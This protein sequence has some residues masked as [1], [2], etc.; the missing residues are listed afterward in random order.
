M[1]LKVDT[2]SASGQ[3]E[4]LLPKR[5]HVKMGLQHPRRVIP[6]PKKPTG[7]FSIRTLQEP[8]SSLRREREGVE[9]TG[10]LQQPVKVLSHVVP[11]YRADIVDGF[12]RRR[13]QPP[14]A[15]TFHQIT[16]HG[17]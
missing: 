11:A 3:T 8:H 12:R 16:Q 4:S 17:I 13:G 6:P 5:N 7:S 1:S 15:Q 14:V 9:G 2:W 10:Y